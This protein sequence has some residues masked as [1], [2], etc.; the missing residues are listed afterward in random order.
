VNATEH[1]QAHAEA[2]RRTTESWHRH[3]AVPTLDAQAKAR[4]TEAAGKT[5]ALRRSTEYR[6]NLPVNGE[7]AA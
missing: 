3:A 7:G 1:A 2:S 5:D 6:R 4:A